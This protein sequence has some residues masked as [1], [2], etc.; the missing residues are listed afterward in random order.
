MTLKLANINVLQDLQSLNGSGSSLIS[1]CSAPVSG[2]VVYST[3][4]YENLTADQIT[5]DMFDKE[6]YSK[7]QLINNELVAPAIPYISSR[8]MKT[9]PLSSSPIRKGH[10]SCWKKNMSRCGSLKTSVPPG[11]R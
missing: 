8:Q 11:Q 4:G 2:I 9:G 1:L 3:D 7:R 5:Q 6:D 10:R